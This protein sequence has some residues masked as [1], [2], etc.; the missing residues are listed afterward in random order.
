MIGAAGGNGSA[1]TGPLDRREQVGL[2]L[3]GCAAIATRRVLPALA[4]VS[5]V[6]LVA[7][8]SRDLAKARA[9][10]SAW[11]AQAT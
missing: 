2:G 11:F 8:A 10:A 5:G 9:V 6:R 4:R 3:L 7:C 1:I